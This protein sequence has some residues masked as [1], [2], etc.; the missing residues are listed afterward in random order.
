MTLKGSFGSSCVCIPQPNRIISPV[1]T[2]FPSGENANELTPTDLYSCIVVLT[3]PVAASHNL[4]ETSPP[5]VPRVFPSGEYATKT[6]SSVFSVRTVLFCSVCVSQNNTV[7]SLL[8]LANVFPSGENA[9]HV[10]SSVCPFEG[11]YVLS[12]TCVPQPYF[13]FN[14]IYIKYFSI[15]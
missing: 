5:Y 15:A 11:R 7:W 13:R 6:I 12:G 9:K 10:I 14:F 3:V 8:L 1:E 4:T 2:V